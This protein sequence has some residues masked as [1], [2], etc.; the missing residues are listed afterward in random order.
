MAWRLFDKAMAMPR[1]TTKPISAENRS[2]QN[3]VFVNLE[4]LRIMRDEG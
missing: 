3:S 4:P 1:M 2:M